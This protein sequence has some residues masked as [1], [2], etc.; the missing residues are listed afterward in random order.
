[1]QYLIYRDDVERFVRQAPNFIDLSDTKL[2]HGGTMHELIARANTA[3]KPIAIVGAHNQ[4]LFDSV[5]AETG[6]V[7]LKV[8]S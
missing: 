2:L 5:L 1:M 6:I 3:G 4:T 8:N 7:P